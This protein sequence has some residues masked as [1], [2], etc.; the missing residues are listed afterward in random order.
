MNKIFKFLIFLI[1]IFNFS[2]KSDDPTNIINSKNY[3]EKNTLKHMN[4]NGKVKSITTTDNSVNTTLEFNKLG[5]ITSVSSGSTYLCKYEYNS[6]NNLIKTTEDITFFN[7][8]TTT[9]TYEYKNTGKYI[10]RNLF[11]LPIDLLKTSTIHMPTL[12]PN[13]S[14]EIVSE[15]DR[16]EYIFKNDSTLYLINKRKS[17]SNIVIDTAIVKYKGSYPVS[18]D[19]KS[20]DGNQVKGENIT[21]NSNGMFVTYLQN[22]QYYGTLYNYN[23]NFI[24]NEYP[25]IPSNIS[26]IN[27]IYNDSYDLIS[28]VNSVGN[29][30]IEKEITEYSN[31]VYDTN[32][33][34][35]S[36]SKKF[37]RMGSQIFDQAIA[38]TRKILYW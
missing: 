19:Y 3:W 2:C 28:E 25:L 11:T 13:L 4:L 33:N 24:S 22:M 26:L 36:R 6:S 17:W 14:A 10:P 16:R 32:N 31:Y 21:Y 23:Y 15:N 27:Y 35:I 20:I 1:F 9:T 38:E 29:N 37:K 12:V 5:F 34:W 8:T 18:F 30:I 7:K